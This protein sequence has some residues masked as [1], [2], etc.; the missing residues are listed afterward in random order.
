VLRIHTLG[1]QKKYTFEKILHA[2]NNS[3]PEST[4]VF[5]GLGMCSEHGFLKKILPVPVESKGSPNGEFLGGVSKREKEEL[6]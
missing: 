4:L 2:N 3:N 5:S 6:I 1:C